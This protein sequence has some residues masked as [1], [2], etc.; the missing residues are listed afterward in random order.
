MGVELLL[1]ASAG[2]FALLCIIPFVFVIVISLTDEYSL[3][4]KGYSLV[5]QALIEEQVADPSHV[6]GTQLQ[7]DVSLNTAG[8]VGKPV[9]RLDPERREKLFPGIFQ[10]R[11]SR[12][13][14]HEGREN[15]GS[16]GIVTEHYTRLVHDRHGEKLLHPIARRARRWRE[17]VRVAC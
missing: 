12:R 11:S 13:S 8:G 4:S 16:S 7:P 5:P 14:L 17:D 6:Y 15:M 9:Y 1:N 2:G 10:E 3:V